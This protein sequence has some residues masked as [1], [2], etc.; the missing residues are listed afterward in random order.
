MKK[1][2]PED[3]V[4]GGFYYDCAFHPVLCT[5][6]DKFDVEGISLIDGSDLRLCS[7]R[8]CNPTPLTFKQALWIKN[9]GPFEKDKKRL[10][11]L[12]ASKRLQNYKKWWE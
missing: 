1:G 3:I 9:N 4:V 6:V 7:K 11:A 8:D 2:K 10:D 5:R 12:I